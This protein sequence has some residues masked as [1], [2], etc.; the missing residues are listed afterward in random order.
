M[1]VGASI[2]S[3]LA[4]AMCGEMLNDATDKCRPH[5]ILTYDEFIDYFRWR[6]LAVRFSGS[7]CQCVGGVL[8]SDLDEVWGERHYWINN[9][10]KLP[11]MIIFRCYFD[12]SCAA[13]VNLNSDDERMKNWFSHFGDHSSLRNDSPEWPWVIY[14]EGI[15]NFFSFLSFRFTCSPSLPLLLTLLVSLRGDTKS[16][17][18]QLLI[19]HSVTF[20]SPKISILIC[21]DI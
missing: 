16:L 13:T 17:N 6:C 3:P 19:P 2:H 18:R 11:G 20:T 12:S 7:A 8:F 10:H 4:P 21:H 9:L 15:C 1:P 5:Q 14:R